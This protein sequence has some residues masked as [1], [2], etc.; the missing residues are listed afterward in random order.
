MELKKNTWHYRVWAWT[1]KVWFQLMQGSTPRR[2]VQV[3]PETT[4]ICRYFWRVVLIGPLT[5]IFLALLGALM[6]SILG[7]LLVAINMV[8]I[9][10]A[11]GYNTI[12]LADGPLDLFPFHPF[13]KTQQP[14]WRLLKLILPCT[15]VL[16]GLWYMLG[17]AGMTYRAVQTAQLFSEVAVAVAPWIYPVIVLLVILQAARI[18]SL[19]I[20]ISE[21]FTDVAVPF[22]K[23]KYH[24]YCP[25]VTFV[26]DDDEGSV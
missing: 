13:E 16:G 17:T 19:Y 25:L 4:S 22:A 7:S 15:Y 8:N 26:D 11:R 24:R 18:V 3:M 20:G 6:F 21:F 14:G 12:D 2:E 23:A 1:H 9:M 10:L 5:G